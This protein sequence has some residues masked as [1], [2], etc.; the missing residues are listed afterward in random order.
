MLTITGHWSV[1]MMRSL[2]PIV[3]RTAGL[4]S[5]GTLINRRLR[6]NARQMVLAG[7]FCFLITGCATVP[8]IVASPGGGEGYAEDHGFRKTPINTSYFYLISFSKIRMPGKPVHVY[9]EGD[10]LAWRTKTRLSGNPTPRHFLALRLAAMD[11][12]E[13]VV[14]LARPCQ[15]V[16]PK[17]EI[18]Y[19]PVYWSSKRFS[20]EAISSMNEAVDEIKKAARASEVH[21]IGHSGGGAVAVLLAAR[22]HDVAS[23][24]TIAGNLD[25]EVVNRYHHVSPIPESL[26]PSD[27]AEKISAIP[28]EHF[29]GEKDKVIPPFV[30]KG[31]LEKS[32]NAYTIKI[33]EIPNATHDS[34]WETAWA[35]HLRKMSA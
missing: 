24:C 29:V 33:T 13:N 32:H 8:G 5:H 30:A 4:S 2:N 14:Y 26:N 11:P 9:I 15:Y 16:S 6:K 31:F 28:Q 7:V 23:L 20:E 3:S 22:R 27:Q 19:D 25:S 1:T 17:E 10:G 18:H 12:S 34:G 35:D 21:L